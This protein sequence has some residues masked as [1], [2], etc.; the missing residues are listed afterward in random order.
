MY[1]VLS[2]DLFSRWV[3]DRFERFDVKVNAFTGVIFIIFVRVMCLCYFDL[4]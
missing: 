2:G 4:S 1:N 3:V